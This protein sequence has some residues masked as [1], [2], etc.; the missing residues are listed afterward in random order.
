M[1]VLLDTCVW[2]GAGLICKPLAT[3]SFGPGTC[4]PIRATYRSSTKPIVSSACW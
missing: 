1:K 3:T 4:R 2:G